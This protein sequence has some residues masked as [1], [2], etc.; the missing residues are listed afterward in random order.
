MGLRG[1]PWCPTSPGASFGVHLSGSSP[2][3]QGDGAA[4][5]S[6]CFGEEPNLSP[7]APRCTRRGCFSSLFM[8]PAIWPS[9]ITHLQQFVFKKKTSAWL[10]GAST[11]LGFAASCLHL[12][13]S[14]GC[15]GRRVEKKCKNRA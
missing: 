11:P 14:R 2:H 5:C 6:G 13:L 8:E 3:G 12:C 9:F 15:E 10:D 7:P 1:C 4:L